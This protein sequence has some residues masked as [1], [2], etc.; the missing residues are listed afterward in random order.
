MTGC[1]SGIGRAT[2]R[3]LALAGFPTWASARRLDAVADL[4]QAGCRLLQLDVTDEGSRVAAVAA[5]AAEHGAVGVL[6]NNAGHGLGGPLEEIPLELVRETFETNVFG[7]LRLCQLVVPGMRAQH[8]GTIVNI[9][10]V[11]GLLTPPGSGAYSM[12]KYSVESLSDAL[13]LELAPFGI[14]T[15]LIEPGVVQTEFRRNS[16]QP[17]GKPEGASAYQGFSSRAAGLR[18]QA[19]RPGRGLSAEDVARVIVGAVRARHPRARYPVGAGARV[20]PLARR[21]LEDRVW[22]AILG[23]AMRR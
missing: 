13:R 20:G 18:E 16:L 19:Y 10:S 4:E 1:S 9:G 5:V 14:R 11:A 23:R 12:T 8:R 15:I 7:L 2:A 21:V 3:A 17:S 22:D 6:V